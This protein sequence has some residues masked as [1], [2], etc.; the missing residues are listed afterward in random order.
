[1][2]DEIS[3]KRKRT[4]SPNNI[5]Q[6]LFSSQVSV[7]ATK[8][9]PI[10]VIKNMK[11]KRRNQ[12]TNVIIVPNVSNIQIGEEAERTEDSLDSNEI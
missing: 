10:N 3:M 11:K 4:L 7:T 2:K 8:N 6:N 12:F 5:I 9:A 1:M